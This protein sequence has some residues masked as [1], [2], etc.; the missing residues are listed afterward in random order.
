MPGKIFEELQQTKPFRFIEEAFLN[1]HRT[2]HMLMQELAQILKPF[3]V[4][5]TQYNVLRI[6]RGAGA[7]GLNCKDIGNR[8]ITREPDITRLLDRLQKR[9]LIQRSRSREDRRFA[10]VVITGQGLA[11]LSDLDEPVQQLQVKLLGHLG[12]ASLGELIQSLETVRRTLE[13]N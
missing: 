12:Q 2:A 13:S 5:E 8:M 11:M 10:F 9:S 7:R 1:I 3:G 4:S 6:L